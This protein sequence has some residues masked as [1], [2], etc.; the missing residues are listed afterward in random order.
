MMISN[1]GD[2]IWS[3]LGPLQGEADLFY[4]ENFEM[5]TQVRNDDFTIEFA[6]L[7]ENED[8]KADTRNGLL[9]MDNLPTDMA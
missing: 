3:G 9:I 8:V 1:Q 6:T 4:T 2:K 5:L 7:V